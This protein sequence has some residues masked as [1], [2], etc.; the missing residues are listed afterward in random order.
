[1]G[2]GITVT[3]NT[4]AGTGTGG[5]VVST[6]TDAG[7]LAINTSNAANNA[8][9][10]ITSS[11]V[12]SITGTTSLNAGAAND[13]TLS[14]ANN[15]GGAVSVVSGNNVTLN[16]TGAIDLG[17]S[18]V[19]GNLGVTAAGA[20]T[21]SGN[22]S[23]AGTTTVTPGAGNSIILDQ[24]GN[25]FGGAFSV[26][27][28]GNVTV[29]DASALNLGAI[30][31]TGD[32]TATATTGDISNTG[33][34]TIGGNSSFT[35]NAV[36]ASIGVA[37]AGNNFTGTV[38]FGGVGGLANV[39]VVDVTALDLQA[40]TLSGN[41]NVT[42][43]GM[44]NSG[45]LSVT[46]TTSLTAG[47]GNDITLDS[48]NNFGG[49][50]TVVS[51]N[52][53]TLNDTGAIDLAA[54]TVSGNL[55]ITA[56]GAISDSGN[57]AITGTT[58]LT[59][60]AA[61][62]ITLDNANNFGGAVTVVSGDNVTLNDIGAIDLGASTVSGNLVITAAGA[63]T[64]SGNLAIVG[65]T[66]LTA[67]AANNITL[68]NA[69]NFGSAVTVISGSNV[70]LNDIGAIDL[71]ATT[72]SGN[73]VITAAGAITDSGNLAIT[74]TTSLAAGAANDIALDSANNFG[75]TVTVVSGKDVRLNDTGS[76]DLASS[77]VSGYLDVTAGSG[78]TE[79]GV[80]TVGGNLWAFT[81]TGDILLKNL[82]TLGGTVS[83][84]AGAGNQAWLNAT[85]IEVG[86]VRPSDLTTTNVGIT[87]ANVTLEAPNGSA[88]ITNGTEGLV[89]ATAP[90]GPT[91]ALT[92][93]TLPTNGVIG[94]ASAPTIKGLR[95]QTSGLV[96]VFGDGIGDG[97]IFL[98][99][100][101]AVQPKYEFSGDPLH[102][103]VKYNGVDATN[104]QLTG[105]LDAA[106]LDIRNQTTEIRES[107]FAKENASKVLRRGV[108]TSAGP[109]QPA[110]D[111]S[112][113]LA[114]M[115]LCDGIFG[116]GTLACQ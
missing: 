109:G 56:A 6:L 53:V 58:S 112:T 80:L 81:N 108:V 93:R 18:T 19:S 8:G 32:L 70:T 100:D 60:G 36:G 21:D 55:V 1:A 104:A 28:G 4:G 83:L 24:A 40:T 114:G 10:S 77:T 54:S 14:A 96:Q 51:G 91:A 49:A 9:G 20:I 105:A 11:G 68:D 101:D 98:I 45:A 41:L 48:G 35:A 42:A 12:L 38:A 76:I 5:A 13:I 50:V 61:N 110:V 59:A 97:T 31:I 29:V 34:L 78:I 30:G 115:E 86:T 65:T 52:N 107:G 82:N 92:I 67:G 103:V 57:L 17:A 94:D 27:N 111:D 3:V 99:G 39:T 106:Y 84:T 46:G 102:R 95:V 62:N 113:G 23:I 89:T 88:F 22:L 43:A 116:S 26:T 74:G 47:A 71:A 72:V 15:F 44:T 73:L 37:N 25:N 33:A 2:T 66:N 69:D 79:S 16:D 87:A 64:D 90:L 75:G 7:A 63:I 85:R